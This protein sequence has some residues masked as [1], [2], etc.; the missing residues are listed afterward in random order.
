[1]LVEYPSSL[2]TLKTLLRLATRTSRPCQSD[3]SWS[4]ACLRADQDT[5]YL[6]CTRFYDAAGGLRSGT[7]GRTRCMARN[8]AWVRLRER[9]GGILGHRTARGRWGFGHVGKYRRLVTASTE[10]THVQR[11]SPTGDWREPRGKT[12]SGGQ[13]GVL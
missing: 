8:T 4:L 7:S 1:M 9:L 2:G 6:S 11:S 5:T 13:F 10:F 12:K 3:S